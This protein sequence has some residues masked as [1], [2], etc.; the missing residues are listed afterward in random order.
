MF[1][2]QLS[3][4]LKI[5]SFTTISYYYILVHKAIIQNSQNHLFHPFIIT[6]YYYSTLS[7]L[8][9]R[10]FIRTSIIGTPGIIINLD[11]RLT[12]VAR[13]YHHFPSSLPL[14][15]P[16]NQ[17]RTT[18]TTGARARACV[19]SIPLNR[20]IPSSRD[21][22]R[23]PIRISPRVHAPP[24]VFRPR[25]DILSRFS[26]GLMA[27][28]HHP[29][30]PSLS[31]RRVRGSRS[32]RAVNLVVR[33][34][35][36]YQRFY[37]VCRPRGPLLLFITTALAPWR[38]ANTSRLNESCGWISKVRGWN[39][40]FPV[41]LDDPPSSILPYLPFCLAK[42]PAGRLDF[43]SLCLVVYIGVCV[44]M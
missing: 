15:L 43:F 20:N 16:I 26:C 24:R 19:H 36:V 37:D 10:V 27:H 2:K 42:V 23:F 5:I 38:G 8:V 35:R 21:R 7:W 18:R 34:P 14:P 25:S 32:F 11:L 12:R 4:T 33:H 40:T 31:S 30:P 9:F 22:A 39:I 6:S 1:I 17:P 13:V 41:C 28:G 3:K 44:C 29:F